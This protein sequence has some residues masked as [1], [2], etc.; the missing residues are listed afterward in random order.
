VQENNRL[1]EA[2]A[3]AANARGLRGFFAGIGLLGRG[4][5]MWITSPKLMLLG[6]VPALIVG[7]AY[8]ALIVVFLL[9]LNAITVWATPF[10]EGW[11]VSW[12]N[13]VRVAVGAALVALAVLVLVY[14][15]AAI[16][17]AVGDPFYE[18]I[19]RKVETR[20]GDAPQEPETGL[21]KSVARGVGNGV[22][23][24]LLTALVGLSLLVLGLI[25]VIGQTL[26]PLLGAVFGG[27]LLA[28]ELTGFAFDSRGMSLRQRRRMLGARRATALGF[29]MATYLLF[30]IPLVAVVVMPAAVAGATLLSRSALDAAVPRRA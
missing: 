25:P 13:S 2:V 16:T 10:A 12:R 7:V 19:W 20:L 8:T 26:V 14:T 11:D 3:N 23:L 24:L 17:L 9:N 1:R 6:A 29:G 22:R 4:L 5:G 28:V 27:W 30:L 21:W 18:R 15:F